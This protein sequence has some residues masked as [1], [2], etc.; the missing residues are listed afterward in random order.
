MFKDWQQPPLEERPRYIALLNKS[1]PTGRIQM[2]QLIERLR[3]RR[4]LLLRAYVVHVGWFASTCAFAATEGSG[5]GLTTSLLLALIT[6]PPVLLYTVS[7]HKACR[8]VDP[9]SRT[10]GWKPIIVAT[11]LLTPFESGL[12]LPVRNLWVARSM[13]RA[14]EQRHAAS[15]TQHGRQRETHGRSR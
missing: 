12:I 3:R 8:A 6:V 14:W 4:L 2:H 5:I 13:I 11:I 7:V 15:R 1:G 9:H 10:V